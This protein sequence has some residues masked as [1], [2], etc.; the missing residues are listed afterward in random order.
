NLLVGE[1]A[2]LPPVDA[3]AP[4]KLVF[5]KHWHR[6]KGPSASDVNE[7]ARGLVVVGRFLPNIGDLNRPFRCDQMCKAGAGSSGQHWAGAAF[8]DVFRRQRAMYCH[9]AEGI[10]FTK[11][12]RAELGVAY[13]RGVLQHRLEYR[14]QLAG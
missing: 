9:D 3:D 10:A 13:A 6:D 14:L 2:D 1:W 8:R 12:E 5:F 7:C 4:D 11:H